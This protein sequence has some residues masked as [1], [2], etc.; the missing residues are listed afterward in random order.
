MIKIKTRKIEK[1]TDVISRLNIDVSQSRNFVTPDQIKNITGEDPRLMAKM[2]T[3][4]SRPQI[5]R[6]KGLTV[7][8]VSTR[9]YV[10]AKGNGY[11]KLESIDTK[12][13]TYN[14]DK[15]LPI[16]SS[17]VESESKY[18]TYAFSCGL[19][20]ELCGTEDIWPT[21]PGRRRTPRFV[22]KINNTEIEVD[23]AQIE[24]DACFEGSSQIL[25][26]EGKIGIPSSFN[27]RQLYYPYRT[28]YEKKHIKQIRNFFFCY[29][30]ASRTYSFW[31][32]DF[33]PYNDFESIRLI[34]F[35][36]YR[37]KVSR[38]ISIKDYQKVP[39]D[40]TK[41]HIPQA[42][43]INKIIEFPL[44]VFEGYDTAEKISKIYGFVNRQSSYY[45]QAAEILGLVKTESYRYRLTDKSKEFLKLA[46]DKKSSYITKVLLEFPVINEVFLQISVNRDKV[47]S[48]N[49]ILELLKSRSHLTGNTL[50]RRTRTIIS[51]FRW[52]SNNLRLV[53]VD[54]KGSIRLS[55]RLT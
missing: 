12:T 50:V 21:S 40:E 14:A 29:D 52:I 22:F 19:I 17:D 11:H 55:S 30:S 34:Q 20:S 13:I 10:I 3:L 41:I 25:L 43:D 27:I 33:N 6:E 2:D 16:S 42:D 47:V 38:L 32:Y 37:I 35:K 54:S 48:R 18:L 49:D 36:R 31:E 9:K 8:P 46:P 24:V 28:L 53:E 4:E 45:R 39:I 26:F 1:W 15:P 23:R 51:W 7:L 44:R 5:F